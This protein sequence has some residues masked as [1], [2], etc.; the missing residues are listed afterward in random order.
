[1]VLPYNRVIELLGEFILFVKKIMYYFQP[2]SILTTYH[3]DGSITYD[4]PPETWWIKLEGEMK[5]PESRF[6]PEVLKDI[7]TYHKPT[8]EQ[9][10]HYVAIRNAAFE[11]SKVLIANTPASADQTSA[12]RHLRMCVMEA[13]QAVATEGKY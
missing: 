10:V 9:Q 13:N 12:I 1:M 6:T 5:M 3:T 11:F 8:D 7:F 4:P 2:S